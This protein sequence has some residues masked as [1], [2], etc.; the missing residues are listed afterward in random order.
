M[1]EV[2]YNIIGTSRSVLMCDIFREEIFMQKMDQE[3]FDKI[4]F[5]KE[6]KDCR[7]PNV[8]RITYLGAHIDYGCTVCGMMHT[9]IEAFTK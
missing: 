8:V 5:E 7:H 9:E 6:P 1:I 2:V 4:K 3:E